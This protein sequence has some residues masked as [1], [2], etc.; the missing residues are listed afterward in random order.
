MTFQD[1]KL[2]SRARIVGYA[3]VSAHGRRLQEM[4]LLPGTEFS[5]VKVAPLGDPIE[6]EFRGTRLCL[7]RLE[8]QTIAIEAVN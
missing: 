6:I 2:G 7:R 1:L 8:A 3:Q 5:V 4:G